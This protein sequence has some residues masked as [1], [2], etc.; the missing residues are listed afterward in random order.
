V[1]TV[2]GLVTSAARAGV[3]ERVIM[4]QTGHKRSDMVLRY[5]RQANA[6]T[7]NALNSLG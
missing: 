3:A 2:Y 6:F 7:E 1:A 5:V 4:R